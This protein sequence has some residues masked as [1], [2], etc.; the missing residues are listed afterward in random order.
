[1]IATVLGITSTE[2]GQALIAILVAVI[3]YVLHRK[4]RQIH[5]LVNAR[6]D[7]ALG[8]IKALKREVNALGGTTNGA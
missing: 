5:V 2:L 1:M 8:E 6:L 4:E 7:D 3:G